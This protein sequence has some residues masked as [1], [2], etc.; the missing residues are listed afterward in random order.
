MIQ[1]VQNE[2]EMGTTFA[3]LALDSQTEEKRQR[4]REN[5]R[6]A[7][8]TA[9]HFL[10]NH[11]AAEAIAQPDLFV[12]LSELRRLLIQLGEKVEE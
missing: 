2:L 7:Y 6:K 11:A 3:S 4:N 1:F 12:R 8:D 5:A 10:E 9:R